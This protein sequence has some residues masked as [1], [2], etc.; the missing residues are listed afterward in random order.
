MEIPVSIELHF[1]F[2]NQEWE[3]LE[4]PG[5]DAFW[6]RRVMGDIAGI[7]LAVLDPVDSAERH[8]RAA[9]FADATHVLAVSTQGEDAE[10]TLPL[11]GNR[12]QTAFPL[13]TTKPSLI[14]GLMSY[15]SDLLS[16]KMPSCMTGNQI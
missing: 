7:R 11:G 1:R 14:T 13:S 16:H 3:R 8:A 9:D 5:T 6:A 15:K 10:A 12:R 4:A 2:W